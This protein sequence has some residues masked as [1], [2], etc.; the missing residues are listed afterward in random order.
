MFHSIFVFS[1]LWRWN[2]AFQNQTL[3]QHGQ[4]LSHTRLKKRNIST[5]AF[6][7]ILA[8]ACSIKYH[9]WLPSMEG[10]CICFNTMMQ[11]MVEFH[12]GSNFPRQF[13]D[14]AVPWKRS[15][16]K[17]VLNVVREFALFSM[18]RE[19]EQSLRLTSAFKKRNWSRWCK[20]R[21]ERNIFFG[22]NSKRIK[23]KLLDW[24][25]FFSTLRSWIFKTK[26]SS[27]CTGV[28]SR[29]GFAST[30]CPAIQ[31]P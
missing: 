25:Y 31:T 24:S 8:L 13:W 20:F 21:Q 12:F 3:S 15:N 26:L 19:L 7:L 22:K 30:G 14:F 16:E 4:N 18:S 28:L 9:L 11:F 17:N 10:L 1:H 29:L 27:S 2:I 23:F 5:E 6:F